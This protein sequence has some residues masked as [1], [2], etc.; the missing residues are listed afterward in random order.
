[1][2]SLPSCDIELPMA[3][4]PSHIV[5][6]LP[7][8]F[9][10]NTLEVSGR[11]VKGKLLNPYEQKDQFK[12]HLLTTCIGR[13]ITQDLYFNQGGYLAQIAEERYQRERK[14]AEEKHERERKEDQA[15]HDREREEDKARSKAIQEA[16]DLLLKKQNENVEKTTGGQGSEGEA[17]MRKLNAILLTTNNPRESGE[18]QQ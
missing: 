13:R 8:D 5:L 18:K 14:E 17:S 3:C 15:I 11:E 1:M 10:N 4:F 12:V 16:L 9:P 6:D 2:G 7:P